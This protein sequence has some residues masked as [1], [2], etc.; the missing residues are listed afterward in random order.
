M[1]VK[2][3]VLLS[4]F[5]DAVLVP[6]RAVYQLQHLSQVYLLTDSATLK[7]TSVETGPK[8]G[9]GWI[10][11]AGINAGDKVAIVGSTNLTPNAKIEPIA[12]KWPDDSAVN[13]T[14]NPQ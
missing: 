8:S 6:Q 11:K 4:T 9:D 1:Y 12:Q 7:A 10:I 5:R 2:A 13:K 14:E 3:R